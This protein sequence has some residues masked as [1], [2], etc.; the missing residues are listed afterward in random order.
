M[1]CAMAAAS[2]LVFCFVGK[3]PILK[4]S[5]TINIKAKSEIELME[6][7][8]SLLS[9]KGVDDVTVMPIQKIAYLRVDETLFDPDA[10]AEVPG[11]EIIT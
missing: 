5:I 4:E 1:F 8:T 9:I 10:A 7:E 11:V 2:L 6:L 3:A